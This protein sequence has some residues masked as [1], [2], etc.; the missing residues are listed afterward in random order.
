M[1]SLV[2]PLTGREG[3][4]LFDMAKEDVLHDPGAELEVAVPSVV[5]GQNTTVIDA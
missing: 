4:Y 5:A 1:S 2:D 3:S